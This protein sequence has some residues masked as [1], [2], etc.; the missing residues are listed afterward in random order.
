MIVVI[1]Q[2]FD[3]WKIHATVNWLPIFKKNKIT[4]YYIVF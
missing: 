4:G 3:K 2:F 1:K